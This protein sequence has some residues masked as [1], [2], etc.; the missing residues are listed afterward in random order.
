MKDFQIAAQETVA[1]DTPTEF[2]IDG[3]VM[4]A[5]KPSGGLL[6]VTMAEFADGNSEPNQ[7]K[8]M[9]DF[10]AEVLDEDGYDYMIGR[11]RANDD[12]FDVEHIEQILT[13]LMEAWTA[14]PTP[15]SSGSTSS[16]G[17]GGPRSRPRTTKQTS[18]RLAPA[19][20]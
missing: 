4:H 3:T 14:R 9:L 18:S 1:H 10:M 8:A 17:N 6:A 7:M 12:P 5:F 11:L 16:P 20:S 15:P 13:W 2:S 19:S